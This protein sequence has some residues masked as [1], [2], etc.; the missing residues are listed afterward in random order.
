MRNSRHEGAL[1][2]YDLIETN[3]IGRFFLDGESVAGRVVVAVDPPGGAT[4]CGIVATRTP[5]TRTI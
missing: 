3:R 1:W 2:A 5:P 4:E